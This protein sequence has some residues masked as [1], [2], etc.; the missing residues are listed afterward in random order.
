[1][2]NEQPQRQSSEQIGLQIQEL[3]SRLEALG[4]GRPEENEMK[5]ALSEYVGLLEKQY[6]SII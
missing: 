1:M 4:N 5:Q 2:I 3:K 6:N